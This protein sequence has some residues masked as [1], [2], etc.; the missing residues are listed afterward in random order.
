ANRMKGSVSAVCN[1]PVSPSATPSVNT[2]TM[3]A[4]ASAICSADCAARFDQARRLKVAGSFE[5][6]K[7]DIKTLPCAVDRNM[8]GEGIRSHPISDKLSSA[9]QLSFVA[10]PVPILAAA[11]G[12][13][14]ACRH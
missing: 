12:T 10:C 13:P 11:Y 4:A 6:S 8:G 5:I 7:A 3:G 2:E 9:R 1:R 14:Y